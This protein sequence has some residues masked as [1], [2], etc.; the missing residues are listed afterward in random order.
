EYGAQPSRPIGP[1][2]QHVPADFR[3]RYRSGLRPSQR[4]AGASNPP[5]LVCGW[6]VTDRTGSTWRYVA[7]HASDLA[8]VARDRHR[9]AQALFPVLVRE[10]DLELAARRRGSVP[11]DQTQT[12][13]P[14][15]T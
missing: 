4:V 8:V 7:A 11:Q 6:S 14:S 2:A 3:D 12:A 5:R 9:S 1:L 15:P 10:R 13:R